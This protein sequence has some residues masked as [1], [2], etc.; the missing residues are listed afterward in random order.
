MNEVNESK[1]R[2]DFREPPGSSQSLFSL[3]P[4]V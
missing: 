1:G 2:L 4:D 3:L